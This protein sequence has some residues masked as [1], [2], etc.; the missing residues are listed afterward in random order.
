MNASATEKG[1]ES[2]GLPRLSAAEADLLA[3]SLC[4]ATARSDAIPKDTGALYLAH[5]ESLRRFLA[6]R[7]GPDR[8]EDLLQEVFL[9]VH[10]HLHALDE[11]AHLR[12]W[13]YRIAHNVVVD[14]H[15][16][17]RTTTEVPETLAAEEPDDRSPWHDV[18]VAG[19]EHFVDGLPAGDALVLR[20]VDLEGISQAEL[21]SE[22][23]LSPS[24]ARSRVQR[25]RR[26]LHDALVGCCAL[27]FD[28][29]GVVVS[30]C[31]PAAEEKPV[32]SAG[33]G[34]CSARA[35]P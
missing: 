22:L 30:C 13:I 15:R 31:E 8:A 9:K 10:E 2:G 7:V 24:G 27:T 29:Y 12:G 25:A 21:A 32:V 3:R 6:A 19:L 14:H 4:F 20:R 16:R 23:G 17:A 35:C 28:R 26:R 33:S 34:S 11:G 1:S 18:V 5:H